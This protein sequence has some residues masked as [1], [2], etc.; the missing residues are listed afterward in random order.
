MNRDQLIKYYIDGLRS[1]DFPTRLKTVQ[2]LPK[3]GGREALEIIETLLKADGNLA[4]K[5]ESLRVLPN[6]I[7][8]L[9]NCNKGLKIFE[10]ALSDKD[11]EIIRG[12]LLAIQSTNPN[13]INDVIIESIFNLLLSNDTDIQHQAIIC[14]SHLRSEIS[15]KEFRDNLEPLTKHQNKIIKESAKKA[16]E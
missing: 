8:D 1:Q 15:P 4:M 3:L 11:S 9:Q 7:V 13:L 16:I 12:S 6:I 10:L 2:L 5:L 14:L